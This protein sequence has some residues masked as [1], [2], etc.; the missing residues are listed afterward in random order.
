MK[1]RKCGYWGEVGTFLKFLKNPADF[2]GGSLGLLV[3]LGKRGLAFE[4]AYDWGS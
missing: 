3:V 4:R 1:K 2:M